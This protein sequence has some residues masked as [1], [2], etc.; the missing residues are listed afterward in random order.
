MFVYSLSA[1]ASHM[2]DCWLHPF[3]GAC[4]WS[5]LFSVG[6]CHVEYSV[7]F[8]RGIYTN[9]FSYI[10]MYLN[11]LGG[12]SKAILSE[13]ELMEGWNI[14]KAVSPKGH[15]KQVAGPQWLTLE[16]RCRMCLATSLSSERRL[17]NSRFTKDGC[18]TMRGRQGGRKRHK[19][20]ELSCTANL[21]RLQSW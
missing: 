19:D 18:L 7:I 8:L 16:L 15:I 11:R 10:C 13:K 6:K 17:R 5:A 21:H 14:S 2:L 20:M 3:I 12:R 9:I 4:A 1:W